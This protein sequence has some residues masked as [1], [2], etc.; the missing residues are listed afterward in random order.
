VLLRGFGHLLDRV[1]GVV[2]AV[3]AAQF[4]LYYAQYADTLAGAQSEAQARYLELERAAAAQQLSVD[5]FIEH[6]ED[7]GDAV[8]RASGEIH[9][10]TVSR[11]R[12]LD[13][14][15][16]QVRGAQVWE[17]PLVLARVYD[18]QVAQVL[19][20]QPGLPLSGEGFIYA[21]LGLLL[22]TLLSALV[23]AMFRKRRREYTF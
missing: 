13:S 2:L 16:R 10:T 12:T 5:Q 9:R 20:F 18:R 22:A 4:P 11:F 8:F 14:S 19:R 15:L 17:K 23:R 7:N 21:L 3:G 6:H 1:F